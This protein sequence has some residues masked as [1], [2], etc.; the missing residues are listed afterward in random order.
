MLQY[1]G[2]IRVPRRWQ[3]MWRFKRNSRQ[4]R[5]QFELLDE[6][7]I[8]YDFELFENSRRFW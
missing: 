8:V 5:N 7:R 6:M 1:Y 3:A 4:A 2:N